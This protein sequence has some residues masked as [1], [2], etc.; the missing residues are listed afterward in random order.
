MEGLPSTFPIEIIS[1]YVFCYQAQMQAFLFRDTGMI[2][3]L[4]RFI[5]TGANAST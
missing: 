2:S 1:L 3:L 5:V 4:A